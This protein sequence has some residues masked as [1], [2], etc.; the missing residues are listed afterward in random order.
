MKSLEIYHIFLMNIDFTGYIG[1]H[2]AVFSFCLDSGG[3]WSRA[4]EAAICQ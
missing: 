3:E 4:D 2:E 1:S